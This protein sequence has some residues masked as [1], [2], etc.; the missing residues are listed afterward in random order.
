VFTS[1]FTFTSATIR[2]VA[3]DPNKLFTKIFFTL[4]GAPGDVS[5]LRRIAKFASAEVEAQIVQE[6]TEWLEAFIDDPKNDAVFIDKAKFLESQGTPAAMA[7]KLAAKELATFQGS[8]DSASLVFMHSALDGGML[9]LFRV[10]H[11]ADPTA[12]TGAVEAK[13]SSLKDV[14][15]KG[16]EALRNDHIADFIKQMDR[17][18]LIEK[19]DKLR[20]AWK[21][22]GYERQGYAF[23]R[24]LLVKIDELRHEVSV[25]NSSSGR[26]WEL[27]QVPAVG[28]PTHVV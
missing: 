24:E 15:E 8:I 4:A 2:R 12:L 26:H 7:E 16:Y 9:D 10:I 11:Q 5:S 19:T 17:K 25:S 6:N 22:E 20:V 18:S 27:D 21:P 3:D 14:H 23:D 1:Q 28:D 13:Q